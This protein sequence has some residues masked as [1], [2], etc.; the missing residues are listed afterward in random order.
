MP[1]DVEQLFRRNHERLFLY[2]VRLTGD[3]DLA[4]DATQEAFTRMIEKEPEDTEPR[5]WLYT[6]ATNYAREVA[7]TGARRAELAA[8]ARH[9]VAPEPEPD[10][11][12]LAEARRVAARVRRALEVLPERDQTVLLMREEG[13]AHKEIA[14]VVGATTG[15]VGTLIARALARLAGALDLEREAAR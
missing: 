3:A 4:A 13:F 2:L 1:L 15:S 9:R 6:V 8:G 12:E 7:R 14:E 11:A 10:P 5:A